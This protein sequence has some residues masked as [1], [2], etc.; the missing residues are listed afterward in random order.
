MSTNTTLRDYVKWRGDL[1]FSKDPFNTLDAM[2][3]CELAYVDY[4]VIHLQKCRRMTVHDVGTKILDS[5]LY[6]LKTL[7][8]GHLDFFEEVVQS[9][10]FGNIV[11]HDYV[12]IFQEE[13]D[14]QFSAVT[15][16]IDFFNSFIA[17]RGTDDSLIGW[18]EDFMISFTK[19]ESQRL[20]LEYAEKVIR[21]TR[22][23]YAGS[24]SKGGNLVLYACAGLNS[25]K[26]KHIRH[27]YVLD[28]PG[29]CSEVFDLSFLDG[30]RD[31]V[32]KIIPEFCVIG[33]IYEL[34]FANTS[35]VQSSSKGLNAHDAL[36]WQLDGRKLKTVES[37]A[38]ASLW[39]SDVLMTWSESADLKEREIF[40]NEFFDDLQAGGA[41]TI[42]DVTKKNA[43]K[44]LDAISRS[45]HTARR[46]VLNLA[47]AALNQ[48]KE[49]ED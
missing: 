39:L 29:F 5:G 16:D 19:T 2:V 14:V 47:K 20:A 28:A 6:V 24:H 30:I 40:I 46:M 8:G 23:Y 26:Q 44:V 37:N 25:I 33:K 34:N 10:R 4:S 41:K 35:I 27:I 18:K 1:P 21:R 49:K 17:Y 22:Y 12:D 36:T 32:T 11:M 3:L 9:E 31:R 43:N 13:K 48:T 42:Q 7:T 38:N 45:S 15:F